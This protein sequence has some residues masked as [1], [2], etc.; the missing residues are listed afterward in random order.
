MLLP[1]SSSCLYAK[2]LASEARGA[3]AMGTASSVGKLG[4]L[5]N[6]S[7]SLEILFAAAAM[8]M[9]VQ[10]NAKGK[11]ACLPCM[12]WKATVNSA[13][14]KEKEWPTCRRPFIYG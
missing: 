1:M 14:V 7:I 12:R 3:V 2:V 5:P 11:M 6:F 4:G 13:F 8:G 10:W 9:P